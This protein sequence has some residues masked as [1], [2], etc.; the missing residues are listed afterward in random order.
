MI[1]CS[2][3]CT[4]RISLYTMYKTDVL[5]SF[6]QKCVGENAEQKNSDKY[7]TVQL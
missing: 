3:L 4:D 5:L 6:L 7:T 1:Y 2:L